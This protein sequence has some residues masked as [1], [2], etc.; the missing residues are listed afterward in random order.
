MLSLNYVKLAIS[1]ILRTVVK[2]LKQGIFWGLWSRTYLAPNSAISYYPAYQDGSWTGDHPEEVVVWRG[3]IEGTY[4]VIQTVMTKGAKISTEETTF[5]LSL[6]QSY[7]G[8]LYFLYSIRN[9]FIRLF[10]LSFFL[11]VSILSRSVQNIPYIENLISVK[12]LRN[13]GNASVQY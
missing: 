9:H 3:R 4:I 1:K 7:T 8:Q 12:M 13:L 5:S 10:L 6:L 11:V 2:H